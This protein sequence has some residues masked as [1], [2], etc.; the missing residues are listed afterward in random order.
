MNRIHLIQHPIV[1]HHLSRMRDQSSSGQQ[2]RNSLEVLSYFLAVEISKTMRLSKSSIETHFGDRNLPLLSEELNLVS[3]LR[4]GEGMLRSFLN[5]LPKVSI[6]HIGVHHDHLEKTTVEYYHKLPSKIEGKKVVIVDPV[7]ATG[8][9]MIQIL[10]RIK[11]YEVGPISLAMIACSKE[12][13]D[14]ILLAHPDIS[15]Y[16]CSY[17]EDELN[18]E[19][20]LVPGIGDP[21]DRVFD[22][23]L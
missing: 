14:K 16:T 5:F 18:S 17:D 7:I 21:G 4:A 23:N 20:F 11:S 3:V 1:T 2:Y 10:N 9:T 12:G 22:T 13:S 8:N 19:G 15:I 6:G